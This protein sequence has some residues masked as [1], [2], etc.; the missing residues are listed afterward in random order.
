MVDAT[1]AGLKTLNEMQA[2]PVLPPLPLPA[3]VAGKKKRKQPA[4]GG[5][6][7]R[8]AKAR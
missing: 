7:T 1:K 2:E 6:I 5:Y 4:G 3:G 8:E